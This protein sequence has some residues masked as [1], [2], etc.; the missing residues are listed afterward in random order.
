MECVLVTLAINQDYS[1]RANKTYRPLLDVGYL[2][3]WMPSFL[4]PTYSRLSTP[5]LPALRT[6]PALGRGV[7]PRV[8]VTR[9]RIVPITLKF[10]FVAQWLKRGC[11]SGLSKERTDVVV[12]LL[13]M[14]SHPDSRSLRYPEPYEGWEGQR[15]RRIQSIGDLLYPCVG[16]L[17]G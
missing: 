15:S 17:E 8:C 4:A 1:D 10:S 13:T 5:Y 3:I 11:G 9:V 12:L 16:T 6:A 2:L 7:S 14:C